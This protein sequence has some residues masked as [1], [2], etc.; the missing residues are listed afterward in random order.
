MEIKTYI[1]RA[2]LCAGVIAY[3][4][5]AE[6]RAS[7][8]TGPNFDVDGIAMDPSD[9][10]IGANIERIVGSSWFFAFEDLRL[11]ISDRDYNDKGGLLHIYEDSLD[12]EIIAGLS[13]HFHIVAAFDGSP[14]KVAL[15]D[16]NTGFISYT[17]T[18]QALVECLTG[19]GGSD[20][21]PD[22]DPSTVP[23]PASMLLIGSAIVL[24]VARRIR[25]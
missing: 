23:E 21:I 20:P 4:A 6:V 5:N 10:R 19:C 13:A 18:Q 3:L 7:T 25:R 11:D 24:G 14:V 12:M 8:F 9:P 22:P 15:L 1:R 16:V 2:L 17:G